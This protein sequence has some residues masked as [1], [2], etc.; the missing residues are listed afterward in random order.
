MLDTF[1]YWPF[2]YHRYVSE[3]LP[4][5]HLALAGQLAQ[6]QR[7]I[8]VGSQQKLSLRSPWGRSQTVLPGVAF[9][10]REASKDRNTPFGPAR[11][12][13]RE[14]QQRFRLEQD[15]FNWESFRNMLFQLPGHQFGE[16]FPLGAEAHLRLVYAF[17]SADL[18]GSA[19][20][21]DATEPED[22]ELWDIYFEQDE[23]WH[24]LWRGFYLPLP[25]AI[26]ALFSSKYR[27]DY[28]RELNPFGEANR[29]AL[30]GFLT[31][32]E[33]QCLAYEL[34]L[35]RAP[36]LFPACSGAAMDYALR[37]WEKQINIKDYQDKKRQYLQKEKELE[38]K[39]SLLDNEFGFFGDT[40]FSAPLSRQAE[41]QIK[42]SLFGHEL[43]TRLEFIPRFS[44]LEEASG[45]EDTFV[46]IPKEVYQEMQ[47][48]I[49]TI[50]QQWAESCP[51][52]VKKIQT[53]ILERL[54]ANET[55]IMR[56]LNYAISHNWGMMMYHV[57]R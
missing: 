50:I 14:L 28:P 43:G 48:N 55:E 44:R 49:L 53:P 22:F 47:A 32:E 20:L 25:G 41:Q 1:D 35:H 46:F 56:R 54:W 11:L 33:T 8:E 30:R 23:F 52:E 4:A 57:L 42:E 26:S 18:P 37:E 51:E 9:Y 29:V 15:D 13:V 12:F 2:D 10:L 7:L 24:R 38:E 40:G 17:C 3:I 31:P 36:L 16:L 27:K 5:L 21:H 19:K 39:Y 6:L 34:P 45:P